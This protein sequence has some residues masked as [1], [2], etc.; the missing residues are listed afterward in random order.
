MARI[1]V[2][3]L[4]TLLKIPPVFLGAFQGFRLKIQAIRPE[5]YC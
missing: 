3:N 5:K 2:G 1:L 4:E